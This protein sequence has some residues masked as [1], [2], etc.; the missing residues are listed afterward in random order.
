MRK[1]V[2]AIMAAASLYKTYLAASKVYNIYTFQSNF[3]SI[4]TRVII[5]T[6]PHEP[7]TVLYIPM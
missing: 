3:A 4:Y 2:V 1:L 6:I 7:N 5:Q